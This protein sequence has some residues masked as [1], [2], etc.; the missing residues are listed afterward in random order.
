MANRKGLYVLTAVLLWSV[1]TLALADGEQQTDRDAADVKSKESSNYQKAKDFIPGEDVVTPTGKK[2]K[3]WSTKGP[4]DVDRAPQ[5]FDDPAHAQIPPGVI[6]DSTV[7]DRNRIDRDP[8]DPR[9]PRD[10]NP[11]FPGRGS[12]L[13]AGDSIPP[14]Q[15]RREQHPAAADSI[16]PPISQSDSFNVG[17]GPPN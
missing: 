3:V 11:N 9:D 12:R 1:P 16:P 15:S 5:P 14:P 6:V 2:V 8:S 13:P 7:L 10:R 4:V 17:G